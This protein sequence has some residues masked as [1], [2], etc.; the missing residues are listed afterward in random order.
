MDLLQ[1][2]TLFVCAMRIEI[3]KRVEMRKVIGFVVH[4]LPSASGCAMSKSV[5]PARMDSNLDKPSTFVAGFFEKYPLATEQL[6]VH[7]D[8]SYFLDIVQ[9]SGQKPAP[10]VP[11]L[12]NNLEVWFKKVQPLRMV[13]ERCSTYSFYHRNLSGRPTAP[14]QTRVRS[15]V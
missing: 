1:I 6:L 12:D 15:R 13:F 7:E 11:I 10:F 3:M 14:S 4:F 9:R 2:S 8:R 5:S